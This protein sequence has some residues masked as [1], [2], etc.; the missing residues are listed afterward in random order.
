MTRIRSWKQGALGVAAL[1]VA[2]LAFTSSLGRASERG[3]EQTSTDDER[4]L[5]V[6][7]ARIALADSFVLDERLAGR[8]V[9]R[10]SGAL[11]FERSGRIDHVAVREGD[12]AATGALLAKLDTREL[13]AQ[14]RELAARLEATRA[15]LELA[16]VTVSRQ[17][18]L[19]AAA[20]LSPQALDEAIANERSLAARLEADRAA[21][22]RVE[23]GLALSEIRAPYDLIVADRA[24]DEGTVVGAGQALF[25]VLEDAPQRVEIGVPPEIAARLEPGAAYPVETDAGVLEATLDAVVPELDPA[26]RTQTAIFDVADGEPRVPNGSLARIRFERRIDTPGAWV[27]LGALAEGRRGTWSAF[28]VVPDAEGALRAER[29]QVEAIHSAEDR[30]FVRGTLRDGDRLVVD[31]LHRL[32]PG[33]RVRIEDAPALARH[34][35]KP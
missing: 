32:A 17:D 28:A 34:G 30:V 35:S 6:R 24:L 18:Q 31:G 20:F 5:P 14:R 1:A 26:T 3:A 2:A 11:G 4:A 25:G 27:P 9:P 22:E 10:R 23:V 15:Q 29:R 8:V 16:R 13:R 12:R 19:H 7:V 21:L 33:L